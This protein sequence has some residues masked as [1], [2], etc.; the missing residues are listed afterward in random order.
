[1]TWNFCNTGDNS[2]DFNMQFDEMLVQ[3]LMEQGE[4]QTVRVYRWNPSAISIGYHQRVEDIDLDRCKVDGIGV[5]RRPTGGRA[6]LHA[7]ELTYSVVMYSDR[8]GIHQV[9]NE[10]SAALV[11]GLKLFGVEVT[12]QRSQ[13]NFAEMYRNPSSIPCFSRSARYEIE[14]KGKKL[15]GSAQRRYAGDSG[16]VVLQHGSILCG[17]AHR[18]LA[19]YLMLSDRQVKDAVRED[20]E[21]KTVDLREVTRHEIDY[22]ELST[23]IKRGF[24]RAWGLTFIEVDVNSPIM[25]VAHA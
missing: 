18:R 13:P 17:S 16:D 4:L 10:I 1:M 14:W 19:E 15:V 2:G 7:E 11:E 23:C 22:D 21:E 3:R 6:I 20:L 5:V 24:E 12:L 9:Y 25:R 8:R